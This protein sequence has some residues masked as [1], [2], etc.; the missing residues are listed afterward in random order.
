[1]R[2]LLEIFV[3]QEKV[4]FSDELIKSVFYIF[5]NDLTKRMSFNL[6][7]HLIE[8]ADN[9]NP[10]YLKFKKRFGNTLESKREVIEQDF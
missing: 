10:L 9:I 2:I 6:F 3:K 5:S 1:M 4:G 7:K 8:T